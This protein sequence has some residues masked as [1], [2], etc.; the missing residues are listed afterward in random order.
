VPVGSVYGGV[1]CRWAQCTAGLYGMTQCTAGLYGMTQCTAG[2]QY[3]GY[4]TAG[5]QYTGYRK[6]YTGVP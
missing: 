2:V 4:C 6:V 1:Q 3:T 5:V